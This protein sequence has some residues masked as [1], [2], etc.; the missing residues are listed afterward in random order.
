MMNE[1]T[2]IQSI[3]MILHQTDVDIIYSL[4]NTNNHAKE[5]FMEDR[6]LI[7]PNNAYGHLELDTINKNLSVLSQLKKDI[8]LYNI[9]DKYKRLFTYIID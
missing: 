2:T 6:C 4:N 1:T 9:N 3:A 8:E 7:R 5:E